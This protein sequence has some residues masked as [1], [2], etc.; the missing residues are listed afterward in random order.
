METSTPETP[1][2]YLP[3]RRVLGRKILELSLLAFACFVVSVLV[4]IHRGDAVYLREVLPVHLLA[5]ALIGTYLVY[6]NYALFRGLSM[7]YRLTRHAEGLEIEGEG[8]VFFLTWSDIRQIRFGDLYLKIDGYE[9]RFEI[10]FIP[11]D[12]QREIYRC[13]HR[14][15]GLCP[16]K[17]R[18]LPGVGSAASRPSGSRG[19]KANLNARRQACP[20]ANP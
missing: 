15:V 18:F 5:A 6:L 2:L 11:R 16:D 13:H 20:Q 17:G 8:E 14:A 4:K 1:I 10:P 9:R 3:Q 12:Q 7:G 19:R